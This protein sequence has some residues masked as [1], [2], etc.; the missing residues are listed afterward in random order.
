MAAL[1]DRFRVFVFGNLTGRKNEKQIGV[2]MAVSWLRNGG[3]RPRTSRT[4][5]SF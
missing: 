3:L 2:S 5:W 4:S 1:L